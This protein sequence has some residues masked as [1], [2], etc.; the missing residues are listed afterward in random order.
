[1]A[2]GHKDTM[3]A[4]PF[5]KCKR[6]IEHVHIGKNDENKPIRGKQESYSTM[7]YE[8]DMHRPAIILPI[9]NIEN[10]DE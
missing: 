3:Y 8:Y 1:M 2:R 4:Y 10:L 5:F 9:R 6:E 7:A